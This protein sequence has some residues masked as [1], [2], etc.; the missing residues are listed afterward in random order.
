M[1]LSRVLWVLMLLLTLVSGVVAQST[2]SIRP[3]DKIQV[4]CQEE[5]ALDRTYEVTQDGLIILPFVGAI[6][7]GGLSEGEAAVAISGAL[8][9]QRI[10]R[11]ATVSVKVDGSTD[12]PIQPEPPKTKAVKVLGAV[13]KEVEIPFVDGLRLSDVLRFA[14]LK[15]TAD[16]SAV[17]IKTAD[18]K[19]KTVQFRD[20]PNAGENVNPILGPGD[21]VFVPEKQL[22]KD[23]F[24]L[25]GVKRPGLITWRDGL[26]LQAALELAGGLDDLGDPSRIRLE[27]VGAQPTIYDI[28]QLG[29]NY[30]L[31]PGDKVV[32]ELQANR[33]FVLVM[34]YVAKPGQVEYSEGMTLTQAVAAAGGVMERLPIDR[35]AVYSPEDKEF[36]KP[37]VY[38]LERITRG[39]VG[40]VKLEPGSK[41]EA[42][43]GDQRNPKGMVAFLAAVALII[44]LGR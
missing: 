42:M 17:E 16:V 20:D 21:T 7:V 31:Q 38:S 3:G 41:V 8:I 37:T 22:P 32:V 33:K 43:R 18:G 29:A 34:G 39:F 44:Y 35:V 36:K 6:K 15:S 28:A 2:R 4:I 40:D 23:V 13:E 10:L 19:A 30:A 5:P 14:Q 27:R 1:K 25:G 24:V 11:K 26:T 9:D 12:T